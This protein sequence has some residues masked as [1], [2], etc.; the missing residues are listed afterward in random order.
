[1]KWEVARRMPAV[2]GQVSRGSGK[3]GGHRGPRAWQRLGGPH[4]SSPA[5]LGCWGGRWSREI[6]T[7]SFFLLT[8]SAMFT[9]V[10]I[11]ENSSKKSGQV[12]NPFGG[13]LGIC[14]T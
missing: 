5:V 2:V 1:M 14:I 12:S 4:L 8:F 13:L 7:S 3:Q 6:W 11:E 9:I 10:N